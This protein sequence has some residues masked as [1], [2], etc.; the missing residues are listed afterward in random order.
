M[1]ATIHSA[2]V[3]GL[4][5]ILVYLEIDCKQV[6]PHQPTPAFIMVGLPDS[7]VR[8]SRMRV[9]AALQSTG[10]VLPNRMS[11][12]VNLAPADVR[13]EG[14]GFDLPLAI[15]MLVSLQILQPEEDLLK[16]TLFV[17]EL[18]FDGSLR[19][20]KGALSIAIK[21]RAEGYDHLIVPKANVR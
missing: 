13:K 14:S 16:R 21:A 3:N 12:R 4:S 1:L 7:T 2:A 6:P 8:E 5:A 15:G 18:G 9:E 17:G 11:Y 19:P 20:V 10:I